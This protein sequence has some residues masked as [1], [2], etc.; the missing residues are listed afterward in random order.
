MVDHRGGVE[1]LGE[2]AGGEGIGAIVSVGVAQCRRDGAFE[3]GLVTPAERPRL[4]PPDLAVVLSGVL[5][6]SFGE[7]CGL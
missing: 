5:R 4:L 2:V 3:D 6:Q 1:L 7:A